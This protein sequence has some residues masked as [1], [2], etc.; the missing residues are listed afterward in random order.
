MLR[1]VNL[2][3]RYGEREVLKNINLEI[4]RGEVFALIGATGTG[5]TRTAMAI[6]D[7]LLR[8]KRISNVLFLTDRKMLRQ[9]TTGVWVNEYNVGRKDKRG[10]RQHTRQRPEQ[11]APQHTGPQRSNDKTQNKHRLDSAYDVYAR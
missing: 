3:H 4:E 6:I 5:K 8:A 1:I 7:C 11:L 2:Y 10:R 9:D